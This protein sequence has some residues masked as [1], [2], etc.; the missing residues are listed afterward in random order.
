MLLQAF[1]YHLHTIVNSCVQLIGQQAKSR[2]LYPDGLARFSAHSALFQILQQQ[3]TLNCPLQP[4]K[5]H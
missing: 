3:I 1:S 2:E 5:Q 4:C